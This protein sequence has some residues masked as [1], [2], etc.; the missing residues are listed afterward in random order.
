MALSITDAA[1]WRARRIMR[2]AIRFSPMLRLATVSIFTLFSLYPSLVQSA[3]SVMRCSALIEGKRYLIGDL[4]K[5]CFTAEHFFVFFVGIVGLVVYAVGIPLCAFL[6]VFL[7]KTRIAR[8]DGRATDALGFLVA[9]YSIHRGGIVMSWEVLVM[10]RKLLTAL[11]GTFDL[12]PTLQILG[13]SFLL[14]VSLMLTRSVRPYESRWLNWLE[15]GGLFTLVLTQTLS[16]AYH[17]ID[18]KAAAT[19]ESNV[20]AEVLITIVLVILNATV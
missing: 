19:G 3:I 6:A 15:E 16:L 9:G 14:I 5:E 12:S 7:N 8:G 2:L 11:L 10:V 13:A 17:D 18:T 4:T 20:A 1:Q